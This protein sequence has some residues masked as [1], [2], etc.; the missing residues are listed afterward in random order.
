MFCHIENTLI[1][2]TKPCT[3]LPMVEVIMINCISLEP[4]HG[5]STLTFAIG[6]WAGKLIH[7]TSREVKLDNI[8]THK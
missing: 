7:F 3:Y 8:E 1:Y 2:I 5:M 6:L 4:Y